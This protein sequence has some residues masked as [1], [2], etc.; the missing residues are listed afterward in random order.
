M[1]DINYDYNETMDTQEIGANDPA[2]AEE[3]A[4]KKPGLAEYAMIGTSAVGVG[5]MLYAGWKGAKKFGH[6][7]K[8]R[9]KPVYD[10]KLKERQEAAEKAAA[11]AGKPVEQEKPAEAEEKKD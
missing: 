7:V 8:T 10:E 3:Q 5:A 4:S 9:F 11:E 1:A 2:T 6:W